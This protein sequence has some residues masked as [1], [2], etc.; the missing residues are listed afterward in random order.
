MSPSKQSYLTAKNQISWIKNTLKK[1][2]LY[3]KV[4]NI[5]VTPV[6]IISEIRNGAEGQ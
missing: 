1:Y 3:I 2:T 4:I 6:N 5:N